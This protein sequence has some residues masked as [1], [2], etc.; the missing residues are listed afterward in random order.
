MGVIGGAFPLDDVEEVEV[1]RLERVEEVDLRG[2]RPRAGVG[3]FLVLDFVFLTVC[4]VEE[5]I[6][7]MVFVW[8]GLVWFVCVK[9]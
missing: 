7:A 5:L 2:F 3:V 4:M 6:D 9:W 1:D 8:F